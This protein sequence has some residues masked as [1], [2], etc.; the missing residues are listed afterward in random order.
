M[1]D[2]IYVTSNNLQNEV[3]LKNIHCFSGEFLDVR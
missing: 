3:S 1:E 2:Y